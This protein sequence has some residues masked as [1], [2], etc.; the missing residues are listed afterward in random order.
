MSQLA[1]VYAA[2]EQGEISVS[3]MSTMFLTL[4]VGIYTTIYFGTLY[5]YLTR[6]ASQRRLVVTAITAMYLFTAVDL[7]LQWR[8]IQSQF[9]QNDATRDS[10]FIAYFVVPPWLVFIN[11]ICTLSVVV[12]A[13]GL[14]IWRCFHLYRRSLGVVVLPGILWVME[15]VFTLSSIIYNGVVGFASESQQQINASNGL[16][17]TM[18]F[19][20][21]CATTALT[22][23]IAYK[24]YSVSK[25]D[26]SSLGRFKR[27]IDIMI[28]S[29]IFYLLMLL[30]MAVN[31]IIS[32]NI[33][34]VFVL[35][36]FAFYNY[37]SVLSFIAPGLATTIMVA[38]V[39]SLAPNAADPSIRLSVLQFHSTPTGIRT[40]GRVEN[41]AHGEDHFS[42][43]LKAE[44]ATINSDSES[45]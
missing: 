24:I 9:I 23:M 39:A 36:K 38:R 32:L 12:I 18:I 11:S 4:V 28:Q 31:F 5:A 41:I 19:L 6:P 2:I 45:Y 16:L 14:L 8:Q 22:S 15:I 3:I 35:Q 33:N 7:G 20:S 27:I 25:P 34:F 43:G 21:L 26:G 1:P 30:L 10:I 17:G 13:D 37:G 29:S 42:P 40:L 44:K